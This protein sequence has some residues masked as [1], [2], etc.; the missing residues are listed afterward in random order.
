MMEKRKGEWPVKTLRNEM[1]SHLKNDLLPFWMKLRDD[2]GG[3]YGRV[4]FDGTPDWE[5][6]KGVILHSRIL[7]V[8]AETVVGF[9]HAWQ[10][11]GEERYRTAARE[12]WRF[13]RGYMIDHAHGGEWFGYLNGDGSIRGRGDLVGPWKCP[14]HNGRMCLEIMNRVQ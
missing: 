11:T 6:D 12:V 3:Y 5:A 14:Y 10:K 9:Y 4:T 7:W 2:R 1:E 8:Q 13:I